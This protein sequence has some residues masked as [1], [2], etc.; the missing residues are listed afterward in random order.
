MTIQQSSV[1]DWTQLSLLPPTDIRVVMEVV[2][3]HAEQRATISVEVVAEP[4]QELLY[5]QTWPAVPYSDVDAV[6]REA[7]GIYT[8]LLRELSGPFTD[9]FRSVTV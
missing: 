2:L 9:G 8:S 3:H 7:G 5:L 6:T 1:K 4:H